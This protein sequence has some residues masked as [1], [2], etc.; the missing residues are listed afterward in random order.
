MKK[1]E[2]I[3]G[4]HMFLCFFFAIFGISLVFGTVLESE[5]TSLLLQLCVTQFCFSL[6]YFVKAYKV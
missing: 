1:Y 5:I 6:Q 3:K 2:R 4:T